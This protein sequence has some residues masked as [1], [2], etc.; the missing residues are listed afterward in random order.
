MMDHE[1][2]RRLGRRI[3]RLQ[4]HWNW[5]LVGTGL[6][7]LGSLGVSLFLPNIYRASTNLLVS[8]SKIGPGVELPAWQYATLATYEPFVENDALIQKAI[9]QYHL[10]RAPYGLDLD[11]F[12]RKDI[13]D[14]RAV[15]STRLLEISIEFPNAQVAADLANFFARGAVDLNNSLTV[16]DTTSSRSFLAK[17]LDEAQ[18]NLAESDQRRTEVHARMK[19]EEKEKQLD[20]LMME[21][22]RLSTQSQAL[23][24]RLV[25][26]ENRAQ[27][28]HQ[29]LG[30]EPDT[31]RLTKSVLS[32]RFAEKAVEKSG[33]EGNS[34]ASISEETLNA[35]KE[36]IRHD[37][38][39]SMADVTAEKAGAHAATEN[40]QTVNAEIDR[41]LV[42]LALTQS[43]L[44]K[45]DNDDKLAREAVEV[46]SRNLQNASVN[47]S[48][49]TQ[50]IEQL[51]PA[52]VPAQ[53]VRPR[54]LLNTLLG[55]LMGFIILVAAA[56]ARESFREIQEKG[57]E[58]VEDDRPVEVAD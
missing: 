57:W 22:E 25:Q 5:I 44:D 16:T 12:R 3:S 20:I 23:R 28:L 36:K 35:T 4:R 7:A 29:D 33:H 8:E 49:K 2:D 45:A 15:K 26:D 38:V 51:A 30:Q 43:Q 19:I 31:F 42:S 32:D 11:S 52:A 40:L 34:L 47:A 10:D 58:R 46:A 27:Y 41:L 53:P 13:L 6:C 24:L 56:M 50:D 17:Q 9:E 21:K 55:T 1:A 39:E 37:Y 14:V 54:V 48:S 18:S